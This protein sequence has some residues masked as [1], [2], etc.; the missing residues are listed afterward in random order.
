MYGIIVLIIYALIMIGDNK[1]SLK[2]KGMGRVSMSVTEK[3][4]L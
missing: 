2:V 1:F 4:V 3:W